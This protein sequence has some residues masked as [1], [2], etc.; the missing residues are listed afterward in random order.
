MLSVWLRRRWSLTSIIF[1]LYDSK[2][3]CHHIMIK[4]CNINFIITSIILNRCSSFIDK[5]VFRT[6]Y[7]FLVRFWF[8]LLKQLRN[9]ILIQVLSYFFPIDIRLLFNQFLHIQSPLLVNIIGYFLWLCST[10]NWFT[11]RLLWELFILRTLFFRAWRYHLD[12]VF[13]WLLGYDVF[14]LYVGDHLFVINF[15]K[16]IEIL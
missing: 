14:V 16:F 1:L 8:W 2:T 3:I 4:H 13:L 10:A 6:G 7:C 12:W 11:S 9:V 5:N 15:K